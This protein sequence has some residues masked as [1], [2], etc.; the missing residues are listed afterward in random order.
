MFYCFGEMLFEWLI[1]RATRNAG[2]EEVNL[3]LYGQLDPG[4]ILVML[5][6]SATLYFAAQ[7]AF[8][9]KEMK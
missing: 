2:D 3:N 8:A 6:V 7:Y 5:A 1:A 9:R 4:P